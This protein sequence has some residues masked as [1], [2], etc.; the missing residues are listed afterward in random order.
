M[1]SG[2]GTG[3]Y[4]EEPFIFEDHQG[5]QPF[6]LQ[7]QQASRQADPIPQPG[8]GWEMDK[9]GPTAISAPSGIRRL[10]PDRQASWCAIVWLQLGRPER[11]A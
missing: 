3:P 7:H 8:P 6:R 11:E 2:K 4:P 10:C 5:P 9:A 1:A